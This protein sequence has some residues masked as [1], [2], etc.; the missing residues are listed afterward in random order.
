MFGCSLTRATRAINVIPVQNLEASFDDVTEYWSP[1]VIGQINDQYLKIAKV[2]GEFVWHKHDDEDELF[3]IVKGH[4]RIEYEDHTA[5]L[6]VGQFTIIPKDVMH[7][8]SAEDECWLVLIEPVSTKHTGDVESE[9]TKSI[10][11]QMR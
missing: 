4:L 3:Y 7:R 2:L 5:E 11:Q 1:K 9:L 8:P 10:D 6:E